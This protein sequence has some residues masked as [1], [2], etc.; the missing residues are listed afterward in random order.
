MKT[1][2]LFLLVVVLAACATEQP[3]GPYTDI[4]L[5]CHVDTV[6]NVFKCVDTSRGDGSD[7]GRR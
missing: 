3:V 2:A 5:D 6:R 1:T 4:P 7:P